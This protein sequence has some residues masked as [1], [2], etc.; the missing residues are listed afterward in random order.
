MKLINNSECREKRYNTIPLWKKFL[1]VFFSILLIL[2]NGTL[3][4]RYGYTQVVLP[5][6]I[7]VICLL[8][9]FATLFHR[10]ILF[11]DYKKNLIFPAA[12]FVPLSLL[13]RIQSQRWDILFFF[14]YIHFS[15]Y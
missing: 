14:Y 7:L 4:G 9:V 8:F 11:F 3:Y 2:S 12:L 10:G 6:L 1:L 13:D 15:R 5:I